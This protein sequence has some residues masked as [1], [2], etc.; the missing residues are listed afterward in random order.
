MYLSLAYFTVI[1]PQIYTD[2]KSLV[3]GYTFVV[4]KGATTDSL[5]T[6]IWSM[7]LLHENEINYFTE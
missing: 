1:L 5:C 3:L 4:I 6:D 7:A 2:T